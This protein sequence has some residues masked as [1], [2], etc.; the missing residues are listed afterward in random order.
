MSPCV[1]A[2]RHTAPGHTFFLL[3]D[4]CSGAR[5]T[6]PRMY[7]SPFHLPDLAGAFRGRL[8]QPPE[9]PAGMLDFLLLPPA[10]F[11]AMP[12]DASQRSRS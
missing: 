11:A 12:A 5:G 2:S 8:A 9:L 7:A 1:I 4:F 10:F 3:C 6:D